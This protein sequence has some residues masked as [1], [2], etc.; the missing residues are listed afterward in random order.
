[1]HK[2]QDKAKQDASW[3]E[4]LTVYGIQVECILVFITIKNQTVLFPVCSSDCVGVE[5]H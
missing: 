1:M 2:K 4:I 5:D 3:F